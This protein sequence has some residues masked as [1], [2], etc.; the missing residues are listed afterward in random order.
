MKRYNRTTAELSGILHVLH[1]PLLKV[2][3]DS[4]I[5]TVRYHHPVLIPESHFPTSGVDTVIKREPPLSFVYL[6]FLWKGV[7]F[8]KK[9][10]QVGSWGTV[11]EWCWTDRDYR[12]RHLTRPS[13]TGEGWVR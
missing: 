2:S 13:K 10:D 1:M 4:F 12:N 7:V 8:R 11:R 3:S 6:L 5:L 9:L